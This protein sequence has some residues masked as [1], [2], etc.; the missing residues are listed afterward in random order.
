ML[1]K[2]KWVL[3]AVGFLLACNLLFHIMFLLGE[4]GNAQLI[5]G[6]EQSLQR[7]R[8]AQETFRKRLTGEMESLKTDHR[9]LEGKLEKL[10]DELDRL[11]RRNTLRRR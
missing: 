6:L 5:D 2:G 1:L 9:E 11:N 10:S 7:G 8:Q 4:R 3:V